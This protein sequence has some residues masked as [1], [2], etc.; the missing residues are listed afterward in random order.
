MECWRFNRPA[1]ASCLYHYGG[2]SLSFF[3]LGSFLFIT[4]YF[5]K[6]I[7]I[8]DKRIECINFFKFFNFEMI[9]N[10]LP[11]VVFQ[12]AQTYYFPSL[13]YHLMGKWNLSLEASTLFFIIGMA[14]Y[15]LIL[16]FF[17]KIL[18]NLGLI[19]TIVLGQII[20]I[21]GA[22]FVY[23][24]DF[25]PQT[26]LSIIFGLALLGASGAFI[27]VAVIIQYGK[28]A[29]SID[30]MIDDFSMNDISSATFNLGINIGDFIGPLY[31]GFVSTNFGF[32][33]SNIYISV[34]G[35]LNC[36]YYYIYYRQNLNNIIRDI[37]KNGLCIIRYTAEDQEK[38]ERLDIKASR[39]RK[40]SIS[41]KSNEN[42]ENGKIKFLNENEHNQL[43]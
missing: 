18:G 37:F 6:Y 24:L 20:I 10:F 13:T 26:I 38:S 15:L 35:F 1:L 2:F 3:T 19:L 43:Y 31:G 39:S 42:E 33:Y 23:P 5:I 28:I 16:Q 27:C 21:F 8:S 9:T 36:M 22:P 11:T 40:S 32:K 12:M 29:K 34:I 17:N 14:A 25:L 41:K 4:I 30:N 7:N